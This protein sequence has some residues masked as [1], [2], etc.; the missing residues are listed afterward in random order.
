M[1]RMHKAPHSCMDLARRQAAVHAACRHLHAEA[2]P[3]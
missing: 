3:L 2:D 1:A